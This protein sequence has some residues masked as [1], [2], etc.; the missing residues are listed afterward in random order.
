MRSIKITEPTVEGGYI[1][2]TLSKETLKSSSVSAWT[3]FYHKPYAFDWS[4]ARI[5]ARSR[6]TDES[7]G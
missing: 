3:Q 1:S 6:K 2:S 5:K 7:D 4:E